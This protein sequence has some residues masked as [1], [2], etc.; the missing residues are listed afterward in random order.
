ME[1]ENDNTQ[2][3]NTV[4]LVGMVLAAIHYSRNMLQ[5]EIRIGIIWFSLY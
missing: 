2:P 1:V 3:E 4:H 5:M